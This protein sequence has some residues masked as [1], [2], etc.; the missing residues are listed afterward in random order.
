MSI[1]SRPPRFNP[2]DPLGGGLREMIAHERAEPERI[3][4]TEHLN[5]RELESHWNTIHQDLL[6]DPLWF[7]QD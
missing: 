1:F 4:L 7:S 6:E 5:A 2:V 3:E